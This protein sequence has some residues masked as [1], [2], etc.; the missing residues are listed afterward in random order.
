MAKA[1]REAFTLNELNPKEKV[2]FDFLQTQYNK[3]QIIK[4]ILYDH[5]ISNNLQVN[6]QILP[7]NNIIN[8]KDCIKNVSNV[9]KDLPKD[10]T[11]DTKECVN[12]NAKMDKSTPKDD[13]NFTIDLNNIEDK[14]VDIRDNENK[15][16][17]TEK[18]MDYIL[19]M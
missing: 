6:T 10:N 8:T 1:N 17:P 19:N 16:S 15:K 3:S 4:D 5:I 11:N 7:K 2:I 12:N 9:Y 14:E 18:A 13:D